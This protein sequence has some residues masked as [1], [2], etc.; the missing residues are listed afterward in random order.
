MSMDAN[1]NTFETITIYN[2]MEAVSENFNCPITGEFLVDPVLTPKGHS[3][4]RKAIEEW[5]DLKHESPQTREP[6]RKDQLINNIALRDTIASFLKQ[7][8]EKKKPV[9]SAVK[10]KPLGFILN[11]TNHL[12]HVSIQSPELE[13]EHPTSIILVLDVST[14]MDGIVAMKDKSGNTECNGFTQL[15]ILKHACRTVIHNMRDCDELGIVTYSDIVTKRLN[16]TKMT[17][18]GKQQANSVIASLRADGMTNL[19]GG[20]V[21]GMNM[22]TD[23]RK[24]THILL[25]TDGQ[26]NVNPPSGILPSF[27]KYVTEHNPS[28]VVHTF[29]FGYGVERN[30]LDKMAEIGS[31]SY[32]FIP[33]GT[34]VGTIFV[35][36]MANLLTTTARKV[37]LNITSDAAL[38]EYRIY[39]GFPSQT[40]S[41][42]TLRVNLGTVRG[43]QTKDIVFSVPYSKNMRVDLDYDL[44]GETDRF[45]V[46]EEVDVNSKNVDMSELA[47]LKAVD[48]I[49]DLLSDNYHHSFANKVQ[50]LIKDVYETGGDKDL[51]EDLEGQLVE[52]CSRSDWYE[53][54]GNLYL[55]SLMGAHLHQVCNNFKD[56]GV[57]GYGGSRFRMLRDQ[58]DDAFCNIPPPKATRRR[59]GQRKV[60][61]MRSYNCSANPCF[62]G[63]CLV[64]IFRGREKCVKDL[65]KGD[66]VSCPGSGPLYTTV[67]CVIRT[68]VNNISQL[69]NLTNGL[70]ITPWHPVRVDGVWKFPHDLGPVKNVQCD[71]V[72]NIVLDNVHVMY[73]NNWECVTMG[74]NFKGP[75]VGHPYFG[76]SQVI[77]DLMKLPGW[78]E[79]LITLD[80]PIV[81]RDSMSMMITSMKSLTI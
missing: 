28:F 33:D 70:M 21:E 64:R 74:H 1:L 7:R 47:R 36:A 73:I 23:S 11:R 55:P 51:M 8:R 80:N 10:A 40:T 24:N 18:V 30:L 62:K 32:G 56:P 54:W 66:F 75:V 68:K 43:G 52:A 9:I 72:Y 78:E 53:K 17:T 79:G 34:F 26:P 49:R 19:W 42:Y 45:T 29:G 57:Q 20:L 58:F 46:V 69:V 2:K 6:L 50:A 22:V 67:K 61:S 37:Y 13:G 65:K 35:N 5:I 60:K 41:P 76:S 48:G 27:Q 63:D 31:G 3:Y 81:A 16:L 77:R 44:L 71:Y 4:E 12:T 25:L 14:S 39:G 38:S 59:Q 15:D